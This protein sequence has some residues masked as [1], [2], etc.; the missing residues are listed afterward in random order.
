MR[1]WGGSFQA[2]KNRRCKGPEARACVQCLRNRV[3]SMAGAEGTGGGWGR[4]V[5]RINCDTLCRVFQAVV[6]ALA[7]PGWL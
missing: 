4:G 3:P 2:A 6:G 5:L 1:M 7:V